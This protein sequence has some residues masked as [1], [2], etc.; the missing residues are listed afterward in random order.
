MA[1]AGLERLAVANDA[2][3]Q[4]FFAQCGAD[5]LVIT[6]E[7][8][9]ADYAGTIGAI[10]G[11]LGVAHPD[12]VRIRP[13]RLRRQADELDEAW[14]ARYTAFKAQPAPAGDDPAPD[15]RASFSGPNE[16]GI[17]PSRRP[18]PAARCSR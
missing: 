6:Y 10:L 2:K 15:R 12:A 16:P 4:S 3:W 17:Q 7:D 9:A 13:P 11:W 14:L 5:P 18:S 8:L 1:I